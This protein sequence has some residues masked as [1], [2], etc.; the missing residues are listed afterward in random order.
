MAIQ[1]EK[2]DTSLT[3]QEPAAA[4]ENFQPETMEEMM[5]LAKAIAGSSIIPSAYRN[6]PGDIVVCVMTGRELGLDFM[7]SLR[8]MHVINGKAILSAQAMVGLCQRHSVCKYFVLV[9]S[10]NKKATYSTHRVGDPSPTTY[11]Y[12]IEMASKAQLTKGPTWQRHPDAMLRARAQSAL[13]RT[14]YSDLMMGI[15]EH[16]EGEEIA[17]RKLPSL[18]VVVEPDTTADVTVASSGETTV[19]ADFE[20]VPD[21]KDQS[22]LYKNLEGQM[23]DLRDTVDFDALS[24]LAEE[25]RL[26]HEAQRIADCH[27]DDL[28]KLYLPVR[29]SIRVAYEKGADA[30]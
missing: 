6:K 23:N 5:R 30:S 24:S 19:D 8:G 11:S 18:E 22:V 25:V 15:Y 2:T 4:A 1:N 26:H 17:G 28:A 29:D 3:V 9:E 10:T 14:V 21:E 16:G 20:M 27:R 13:A 7:Q 12:T